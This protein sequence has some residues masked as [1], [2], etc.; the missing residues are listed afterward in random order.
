MPV[1]LPYRKPNPNH[2]QEQADARE[3]KRQRRIEDQKRKGTYVPTREEA[4]YDALV[5]AFRAGMTKD[6]VRNLV[7]AARIVTNMGTS[8]TLDMFEKML[9]DLMQQNLFVNDILEVTAL[10]K[11]GISTPI[12]IETGIKK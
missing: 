8:F 11:E 1:P 12:V 3:R 2:T 4:L 10:E 5:P 9:E 7:M 6:E